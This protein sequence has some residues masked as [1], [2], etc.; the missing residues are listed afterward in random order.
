MTDAVADGKAEADARTIADEEAGVED[1]PRS[2]AAAGRSEET[3]QTREI[4]TIEDAVYTGVVKT[5][6]ARMAAAEEKKTSWE[7]GRKRQHERESRRVK[8]Q[9]L[10]RTRKARW[11]RS[12]K[13]KTRSENGIFHAAGA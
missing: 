5:M 7:D 4:G 13:K 2:M 11:Q 1:A 6:T 3:T 8:R 10:C 12:P 9:E